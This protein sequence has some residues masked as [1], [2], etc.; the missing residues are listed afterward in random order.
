MEGWEVTLAMTLKTALLQGTELLDEGTVPEPRLTAEVLLCFALRRER[1]Y[2]YSH[3]EHELSTL[4]WLHFGR[5]LHERLKGKPTQY[6][7][8]KQEFYGRDFRVTPDVL[9][10]RP[11]T[12]HSVERALE[13]ARG[14][15][16][17]LDIGTGSGAL[18]VTL[19]LELR[20]QL[21]VATD[22][23]IKALRVARGNAQRLGA[24]VE[25]V[26]CDLSSAVDGGF[27]LVVSNPPYIPEGEI[28]HL[29]R[30]VRDWEPRMALEGGHDGVQPY[31][32]IVPDAERLLKPGGWLIFEIGYQGEEG[33]R[34][35]FGAAWK[36]VT[37]GHDLAGLPRVLSA[38]YDP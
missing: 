18:A 26:N 9:I 19:A 23:S 22:L 17:V 16:R 21:T 8:K 3:P 30:E 37:T 10:P 25:F 12:E 27:D 38:R 7:V 31:L 35:A 2:L 1:I 4:E 6:I 15:R 20:P 13:V 11:E 36:D 24:Q 34:A 33:V 29:Q 5:Y 14:A 28:A 32:R